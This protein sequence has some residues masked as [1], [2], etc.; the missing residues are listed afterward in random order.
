MVKLKTIKQDEKMWPWWRRYGG[1]DVKTI[2]QCL[3]FAQKN[4]NNTDCGGEGMD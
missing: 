3:G 1:G 4:K 2:K